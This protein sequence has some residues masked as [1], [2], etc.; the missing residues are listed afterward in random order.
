MGLRQVEQGLSWLHFEK[1]SN[2]PK[3]LTKNEENPYSPCLKVPFLYC[4]S[5]THP[6]PKFRVADPSLSL[7]AILATTLNSFYLTTVN[8][9]QIF[10]D[11]SQ[12]VVRT[13]KTTDSRLSLLPTR[14]YDDDLQNF[15]VVFCHHSTTTV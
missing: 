14:I 2:M 9:V 6:Q 11:A 8:T 13:S 7:E 5:E 3:I 15:E 12:L 10:E 1:S 4:I